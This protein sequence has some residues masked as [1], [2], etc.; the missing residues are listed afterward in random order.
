M[1][2]NRRR[3]RKEIK[4]E[5]TRVREGERGLCNEGYI[6]TLPQGSVVCP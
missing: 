4:R 2:R 3:R 1:K 6:G 5:K